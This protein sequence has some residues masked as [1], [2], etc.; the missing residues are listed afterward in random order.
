MTEKKNNHFWRNL[1]LIASFVGWLTW[2]IFSPVTD[3]R[4]IVLLQQQ[5]ICAVSTSFCVSWYG[6]FLD[7]LAKD[8]SANSLLPEYLASVTEV[9]SD[10]SDQGDFLIEYLDKFYFIALIA[11]G[12]LGEILICTLFTLPILFVAWKLGAL[13][14]KIDRLNFTGELPYMQ[15][16][17]W[18]LLSGTVATALMF[19]FVP[20]RINLSM[21]TALVGALLLFLGWLCAAIHQTNKS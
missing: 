20:L 19:C 2:V 17:K 3:L 14:V 1:V 13:K 15:R 6:F 7:L 5:D 11:A 9:L 8:W 16:H 4:R 12:R 18:L 21:M 10:I